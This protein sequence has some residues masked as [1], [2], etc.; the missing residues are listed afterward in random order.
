MCGHKARYW[1]HR[2]KYQTYRIS[3]RTTTPKSLMYNQANYT[4]TLPTVEPSNQKQESESTRQCR[5]HKPH[6][7]RS[8]LWPT[9]TGQLALP[10]CPASGAASPRQRQFFPVHSPSVQGVSSSTVFPLAQRAACTDA[11][12]I[13]VHRGS[14]QTHGHASQQHQQ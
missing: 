10:S 5:C 1:H 6:S 4:Y 11:C 14:T 9:R 2:T 13:P 12:C 3:L 8:S 7:L